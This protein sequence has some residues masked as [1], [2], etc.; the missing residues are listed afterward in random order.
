MVAELVVETVELK[1]PVDTLVVT[2]VVV[3][4]VAPVVAV[5]PIVAVPLVLV[6]IDTDEVGPLDETE[7]VDTLVT[8]PFT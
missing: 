1:F 8:G 4:V 6:V 7:L 5:A 3:V 2:P